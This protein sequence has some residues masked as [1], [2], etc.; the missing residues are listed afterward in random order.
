MKNYYEILGVNRDASQEEIKKA[1]RALVKRYHPDGNQNSEESKVIFQEITEAYECLSDPEK[2]ERYNNWGHTTYTR[3]GGQSAWSYTSHTHEGGH[4]CGGEDHDCDGDCA[5]CQNGHHH[6]HEKEEDA[7]PPPGSVRVSVH[8][9][10][11]EMLRGAVKEVEIEGQERCPHCSRGQISGLEDK[12][13]KCPFCKGRG[14][15]TEKRTV[16]VKLPPR[17]YHGCFL[18]L[19]DVICEGEAL[20]DRTYILI[21]FIDA[22]KGYEHRDYHVYSAKQVSFVDLVLGGEIEVDSLEGPVRCSLKPGTR[23]GSRLRLAGQGL[24]MPPK[25]GRRGDH[26]IELQVEIPSA[27]TAKQESALR[28]FADAMRS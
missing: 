15:T 9:T 4:H 19:N 20:K 8:I 27:L 10:Y 14:Y 16:K 22:K 18:F 1:Y 11:E 7:A 3:H 5:N 13:E 25:V 2:R 26:Y 17:C 24:C 21:V 28:A 12:K 6:A 23:S